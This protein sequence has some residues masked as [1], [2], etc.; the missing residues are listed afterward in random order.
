[1][2]F[3]LTLSFMKSRWRRLGM[4]EVGREVEEVGREEEVEEGGEGF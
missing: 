4:E 2:F 3:T 1:M